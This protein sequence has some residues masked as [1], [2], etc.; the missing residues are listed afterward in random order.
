MRLKESKNLTM[1]IVDHNLSLVKLV[2]G[3]TTV[4]NRGSIIAEGSFS[5]ILQNEAVI[6]AYMG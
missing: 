4:I 6:E 2:A 5:E 3:I 1:L